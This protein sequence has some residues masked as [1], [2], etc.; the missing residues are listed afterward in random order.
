MIGLGI[1]LIFALGFV[2]RGFVD[3]RTTNAAG[4]SNIGYPLLDEVQLLLNQHYLRPQPDDN[5]REYAA[6][7]GMLGSLNDRFTF[8]IEPPVAQS[9]SDV[10]AGTYGG[11]GVQVKRAE[12]G[13]L[14]L[15]PYADSPA[16]IAGIENG[17]LLLAINGTSVDIAQQLDAVDQMLRGEVKEGSG[18][19]LTVRK[20]QGA[21]DELT[22]FIPFAVINVPSV[23]WR[24]LEEN[25]QV[26]YV[27]I[28]LFTS[29]TP[30]ELK[31]A[32]EDL[33]QQNVTA[34]VL[35]LRNNSGGLLQE[36]VMVASQF[37]DGGVVV[38]EKN[39]QE[40]HTLTAES[41]GLATDFPLIVLINQGTA[42]AAELVAG[43]IQ[44]RE[45]GI[46]IGQTSFGK[47]T[48]QQIYRLSDESSLHITAAE[49]FT[50]NRH[51]IDGVG[52]EPNISMIPDANGRDVELGEAVRQLEDI[53]HSSQV[54]ENG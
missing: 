23:V 41:G 12:T 20:A 27:Q 34:L 39:L 16:T 7:R 13:E 52:L 28:I 32:L 18:I 5:A 17:D 21:G 45:R 33:K 4:E 19:E 25:P 44:D 48:V 24:V 1:G 26:G 46:L 6:I 9:E 53:L 31:T 29:R 38:Y 47:G 10:L 50:P 14:V 8:F 15:Y 51:Q 43:A 36:S 35:D 2:F 37:L 3:V 54:S 42:S 49:W 22:V 11:I 40:E 30:D